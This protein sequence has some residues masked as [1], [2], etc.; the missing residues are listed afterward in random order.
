MSARIQR[1][2]SLPN[3]GAAWDGAWPLEAMRAYV[4]GGPPPCAA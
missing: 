2:I 1:G 3:F 4:T